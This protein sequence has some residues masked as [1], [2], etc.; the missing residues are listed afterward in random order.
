VKT[1]SGA[2][3]VQIVEKRGGVR[4]IVAHVGSAHSEGDL[5]VLLAAAREQLNPGQD[6]LDLALTASS[7]PVLARQA[8][9]VSTSSA[10]LW[11]VLAEACRHLGFDV[12][13]DDAFS[14]FVLA[15]I[16]EATSKADTPRIL[17]EVGVPS[18]HVNTLYAALGSC[19]ERDSTGGSW[20]RR[21]WRTRCGPAGGRRWS[22]MT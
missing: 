7:D 11:D 9:V 18:P 4:R 19:G 17:G 3:G 20:P 14:E 13:G 21:R 16:I 1:S 15:R 22:C 6:E 10:I 5:A 12:L 2:T 8:R